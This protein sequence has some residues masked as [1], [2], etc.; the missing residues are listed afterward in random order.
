MSISSSEF[1][2]IIQARE[3]AV[4]VG[5][6]SE[7]LEQVRTAIARDHADT[8]TAAL[9]NADAA[10]QIKDLI[11]H[12]A[13]AH[14]AGQNFDRAAVTERIY[15][16]MAGLGILTE[17]LQDP[18]VEEIN[19][20]RYDF[21]EI[22][23]ADHTV[24]LQGS[25][26][27]ASPEAALDIIKRMVRMGGQLLD[28]QTPQ[29]DST[30]GTGIRII[31]TIPPIAPKEY[32]VT[33]SIRKQR[34]TQM[35][36]EELIK[37]GLA[38]DD[39]LEALT[40]CIC[41]RLSIGISG[42]TGSGKSTVESYLVN[43]YILH[44]E[45]QNN[46]VYTVEDTRELCLL[47]YD[48]LHDRP[49]RIIPFTTST[50]PAKYTMFDL[51]K[52]SLR[53]HPSLI[54]PAEVRDGAVFEA[55]I[56]GQSGHT[57]LTSFHADGA[58]ESYR[59]LVTLCHMARTGLSDAIL[60]EMCIDAWPIIV[61]VEQYKDGVRRIAEIFEATGMDG[62]GHVTGNSLYRFRI[63]QTIRDVQGRILQVKGRHERTGCLSPERCRKLLDRGVE[64]ERL[65][66]LFPE[67]K[68][69]TP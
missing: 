25:D 34:R 47:E 62:S 14:L 44:N 11:L 6:Y 28:A 58:R 56:A 63:E 45:G 60:L 4:A 13:A 18:L 32:G 17:Y 20:N 9:G 10:H 42:G 35:T 24:F 49:A 1:L 16:D 38:T 53:Y 55:M 5:G 57:I 68:G 2:S 41:N 15:Q 61:H 26:A 29:V 3:K 22:A 37:A 48:P 40:L 12:Y 65:Y 50:A 66:A 36:A 51:I 46:R 54:V 69:V 27:F 43:Q 30:V 64:P 7:L 19:V 52:G 8:L 67:A 23:Y 33:A 31:A 59:R 21:I 39:M